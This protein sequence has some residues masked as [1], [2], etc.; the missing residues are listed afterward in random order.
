MTD[1]ETL[2]LERQIV[3]SPER[4]FRMLTEKELR[5]AW[6]AP[7]DDVVVIIDE[8]D[9]RPGGHETTRCGPKDNP[10]FRTRADFHRV[11]PDCLSMTEVLSVGGQTL[12]AALC[13][14]DIAA[15]A[16]GTHLIVT[17]QISSFAGPDLFADYS[18]GWTAALDKLARIASQTAPA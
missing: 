16:G 6:S 11:D 14:H 1:F 5:A 9:C 15:R 12:S 13:T 3:C 17:L 4:L 10:E 8:F 7:S 18:E 2:T